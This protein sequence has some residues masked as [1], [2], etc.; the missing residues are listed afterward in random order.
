MTSDRASQWRSPGSRTWT[1]TP[2]F[3]IHIPRPRRGSVQ[4]AADVLG[5]HRDQRQ[6]GVRPHVRLQL[7]LPAGDRSARAGL[8]EP[9]PWDSPSASASCRGHT[10]PPAC[11]WWD[12]QEATNTAWRG[13][14]RS[15]PATSPASRRPSATPILK[16]Q[17]GWGSRRV[18]P[19]ALGERRLHDPD[20][21]RLRPDHA[22][23]R[24]E[25]PDRERSHR[26]R[27]RRARRV[28]RAAPLRARSR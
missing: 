11:S 8:R 19:G 7:R 17:I 21:R 22:G 25:L 6:H 23:R 5:R 9:A 13:L 20:R 2:G 18:G 15:A 27:N 4:H 3:P 12:W 28:G 14:S 16:L 10:A 24:R 1:T 26:R